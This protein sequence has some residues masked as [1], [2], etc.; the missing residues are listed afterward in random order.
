MRDK[1]VI[2]L[3]VILALIAAKVDLDQYV[4]LEKTCL[5]ETSGFFGQTPAT[6]QPPTL[7][8]DKTLLKIASSND[9]TKQ[10]K[11]NE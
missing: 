8:S 9:S 3:S 11:Q 4:K 5:Y 1:I 7:K 10:L 2:V 6:L